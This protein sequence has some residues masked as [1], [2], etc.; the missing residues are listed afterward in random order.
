MMSHFYLPV[1]R[2]PSYNKPHVFRP[3]Q[4]LLVGL[5]EH[6]PCHVV[7]ENPNNDTGVLTLKEK[8][9][10]ASTFMSLTVWIYLYIKKSLS[11]FFMR[12]V[13]SDG[14]NARAQELTL[15]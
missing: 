1:I 6:S 8:K 11:R 13:K 2:V 4:S 3:I 14:D 7:I 12:V 9:D 10:T 5:T 15:L